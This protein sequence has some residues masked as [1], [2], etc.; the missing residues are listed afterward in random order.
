[1]RAYHT[2]TVRRFIFGRLPR[3]YT[4]AV[5]VGLGFAVSVAVGGLAWLLKSVALAACA[6][7]A[8]AAVLATLGHLG[9]KVFRWRA[10]IWIGHYLLQRQE[11]IDPSQPLDVCFLFVDHFEPDWGG[12]SLDEQIRRVKQW[13]STYERAISGHADSDG[14]CPQH[15][16]F[17]PVALTDPAAMAVQA[18]WPGRGW[19]EIEYHLHHDPRMDAAQVREQIRRDIETLQEYGAVPNGRYG[20]VH[21][22]YALAAGDPCYCK[23]IDEIDVLVE[24]G[25]YADYTFGAIG[26]PA[27]PRQVNSIYY[28]RSNGRAKSYDSGPIAE[29]GRAHQGLLIIAGP[30]WCGLSRRVLDDAELTPGY[31]P[32]PRRIQRWL[33]AHVHV[34]GRPNCVFIGVHSH[35]APDAFQR[36]LLADRMPALWSAL[37]ERFKGE[38]T[39]LHYITAREAYNIVKAAEAGREGNPNDYRDYEIPSPARIAR[40]N[41]ATGSTS[42]R[43]ARS[44]SLPCE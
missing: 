21:G 4:V 44:L 37:E 39:R 12:A 14:R 24:T 28:A 23:A 8:A 41:V 40:R 10:D 17:S 3:V 26:T 22:M 32:H 13:Q 1:M 19:G 30:M 36:L 34:K 15:T 27:Q 2:N 31:P 38:N 7:L 33:A 42:E 6:C 9:Y 25:C 5:V 20:F 18:A 43:R 16:W 29:V 35:T 11:K